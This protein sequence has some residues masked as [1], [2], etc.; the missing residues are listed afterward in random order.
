MGQNVSVVHE[1]WWICTHCFGLD[2]IGIRVPKVHLLTFSMRDSTK[3]VGR[4]L[5]TPEHK[6]SGIS[7]FPS[8]R[9]SLIIKVPRRK[10]RQ[11]F[12]C[13]IG[14]IGIV[15][16]YRNVDCSCKWLN[17]WILAVEHSCKTLFLFSVDFA[18]VTNFSKDVGAWLMEVL[19]FHLS[20]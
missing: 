1:T 11:Q 17:V 2:R 19:Y 4:K 14:T 10:W 3:Y 7:A 16:K 15:K 18:D 13:S 5:R 20:G 12:F 9:E 6:Q 8:Y